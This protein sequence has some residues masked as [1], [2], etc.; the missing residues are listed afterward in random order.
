MA[1]PGSAL[2]EAVAAD[3]ERF[4]VREAQRFPFLHPSKIRDANK[5]RPGEEGCVRWAVV[6]RRACLGDV[7]VV[8]VAQLGGGVCLWPPQLAGC[9]SGWQQD[10]LCA[11]REA[12]TAKQ[13]APLLGHQACRF[14]WLAC[15]P[16]RLLPVAS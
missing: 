2:K 4:S 9:F 6:G 16:V 12:G 8:L 7:Y 5:R 11:V 13:S 1:T 15:T 3:A 14:D 10:P